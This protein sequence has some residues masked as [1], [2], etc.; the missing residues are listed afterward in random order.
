[1][2]P[3]PIRYFPAAAAV[4]VRPAGPTVTL[5]P[6]AET[7]IGSSPDF[8]GGEPGFRPKSKFAAFT[9]MGSAVT[10]LV[11]IPVACHSF[12]DFPPRRMPAPRTSAR[13]IMNGASINV[14]PAAT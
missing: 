6:T 3:Y 13:Q 10:G 7:S 11:S 9:N 2:C 8:S 12:H 4:C 5:G 14:I 1:M